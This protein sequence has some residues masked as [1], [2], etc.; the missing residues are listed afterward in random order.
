MYNY[1]LIIFSKYTISNYYIFGSP[2][3]VFSYKINSN[4][5]SSYSHYFF[6]YNFLNSK[7]MLKLRE[8][9][10]HYNSF[11][12][13]GKKSIFRFNSPSFIKHNFRNSCFVV[14]FPHSSISKNIEVYSF[15]KKFFSNV[16][17]QDFFHKDVR[18]IPFIFSVFVNKTNIP[19]EFFEF[20]I[21]NQKIIDICNNKHNFCIFIINFLFFFKHKSFNNTFFKN[22]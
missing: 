21:A 14:S 4:D 17:T 1:N 18:N 20:V 13:S 3:K 15:F 11:V 12:T 5:F 16:D 10:F 7:F 2:K 6:H 9:F 22:K 8:S 19:I